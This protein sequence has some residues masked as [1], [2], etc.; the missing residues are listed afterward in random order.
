L[1]RLTKIAAFS[2][3]SVLAIVVIVVGAFLWRLSLGPVSIGFLNERIRGQINQSLGGL[4]VRLSDAVIERDRRTG[5]PHVRLRDVEVLDSSGRLIAR[6]PRAAIGLDGNALFGAKIVPR[7]IDLIGAR[8]LVKRSASGGFEL[9]FGESAGQAEGDL[10]Q[11][12]SSGST[13]KSDQMAA[14]SEIVPQTSASALVE[15]VSRELSGTSNPS[16]TLATLESI[17]VTDAEIELYDEVNSVNW[18]SP[19]AN[20]S[21]QRMPYGFSLLSEVTIA[22]GQG[23][24]WRAEI[25]TSYQAKNGIYTL[26]ARIFDL[27]PANVADQIFALSKFAQVQ[28]PLSGHAELEVLSDGTITKASAELSAAAGRV[29]LP[30]YISEPILID[31]GS[32]RLDFDP[33]NGGVVI[34][35]S[36]ILVGGSRADLTGRIDPSRSPDGKLQALKLALNARNVSIDP[37][38]TFKQV[39]PIDRIDFVGIASVGEAKLDVEDLLI[40]AGPAG[41]RLR[42]SFTGGERS[43]GINLAGRAREL[44]SDILK[45]LWPPMVTPKTRKWVTQNVEAGRVTDAEFKIDLAPNE[46]ADAVAQGYMA[47]GAV[48]LKFSL[49]DVSTRYFKDL[50]M[51]RSASGSGVAQGNR[52]DLKLDTGQIDLTPTEKIVL[53]GASMAATNLLSPV[54]STEYQ[55]SAKSRASVILAYMD[56]PALNLL[57]KAQIDKS[58]LE[59]NAEVDLSLS[60]LLPKDGSKET[61]TVSAK[62]K[63][64]DAS[65]KNV[66]GDLDLEKGVVSIDVSGGSF[67]ASGPA[68]IGGIPVKVQVTRDLTGVAPSNT[69]VEAELTDEQR[70]KFM[71]SV[72][73]FVH[74]PMGVK[75]TIPEL[76]EKSG[77]LEIA[78]DLSKASL[79]I[80]AISW[81]RGPVPKTTASLIYERSEK[82]GTIRNLEIKGGGL[83][84]NGEVDLGRKGEL[85][86]ARFPVVVLSE[87]NRFG[88]TLK[89]AED[90]IS[91]SVNGRSFD[92]RPLIKATFANREGGEEDAQSSF[93]IEINLDRVYAHRGEV[94]TDVT[95]RIVSR[96]GVVQ[97]ANV[98]GTFISGNPV[99]FK[100]TPAGET[101][102]LRVVGRDA[103]AAL[104]AANLYSKIAGG[105]LDF[106]ATLNNSVGGALRKGRLIIRDFEVRNEAALAEL[107]RKG[108][109]K[110]TGPRNAGVSFSRLTLPFTADTR[111]IRIGDAVVKGP[112]MCATA[113]GI[114]RRKDGAMDIDGTIIPACALNAVPGEIPVIGDILVGDGLFGLTYALGGA[115]SNPKFQ[116]NPVSAIAPGIF[117]RFFE[118]GSPTDVG[119]GASR[120]KAN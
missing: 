65:V 23:D 26:S 95:G 89:Q 49:A 102:E 21:F 94:L 11:D 55:V 78:A 44:P 103:G 100:I 108:K 37:E 8:V 50:P 29:G 17:Q 92:A 14:P 85:I 119:T 7:R 48:N 22:S 43:A 104:R 120:P 30:G 74:G 13:G 98:Q 90:D 9:G 64:A 83:S 57:S 107:D 99:V 91:L 59:G 25:S 6:A 16:S 76:A 27:V 40:V 4:E 88:F 34:S 54:T 15:L 24:P 19:N 115:I 46:L 47:D 69:I 72:N 81:S 10:K 42:G 111:F 77:K 87:E 53:D 66:F 12:P 68:R 118:Y 18:H 60:I 117:R 109:P 63:V 3:L 5:M 39:I 58:R 71:P 105:A 106:Q 84:I 86:A 38:G 52:F 110:K 73:D 33:T 36:S 112:Q 56:L 45:R 116:V 101:R 51:I 113:D 41:V 70:A 61:V 97:Q 75:L 67:K 82:G 79:S 96:K 2:L 62:A 20:L 114:I 32:V 28:L 31:E 35:N 93:R 80:D 1:R